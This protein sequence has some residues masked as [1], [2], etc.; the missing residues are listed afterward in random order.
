MAFFADDAERLRAIS[1]RYRALAPSFLAGED[2][3]F[4][5][6]IADKVIN[7][8]AEPTQFPWPND[9]EDT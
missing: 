8:L 5:D 6:R 9:P 2:A 1:R 4:L 7:E 3:D